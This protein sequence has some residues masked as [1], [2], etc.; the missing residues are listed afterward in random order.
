ESF[1]PKCNPKAPSGPCGN[2]LAMSHSGLNGQVTESESL[3]DA[4]I[5]PTIAQ[6]APQHPRHGVRP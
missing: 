2:G 4:H 6:M 5:A 3:A 1:T